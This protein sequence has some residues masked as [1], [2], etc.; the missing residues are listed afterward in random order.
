MHGAIAWFARNHVA[1][2][3]LMVVIVAAGIFTMFNRIPLEVFPSFERDVINVSASY[4][5]A[6]PNEVEEGVIR[7]IEESVADIPEIEHIISTASEGSAS[8][9]LEVIKGADKDKLL[10]EVKSR[11][12]AI[13][14]LPDDV[15]SPVASTSVRTRENINVIVYGEM[16]E[17]ELN[18]E[19]LKVRDELLKQPGITQVAISGL[20]P[21]EVAIEI[22]EVTLQRYGL[23]LDDV[24]QAISRSSRDIPAGTLKTDAG[25]IRIRTL[26]KVTSAQQFND[27]NIR[28][29]ADGTQITLGDIATIIDG[30]DEG[31]QYTTFDGKR[32]ASLE[33]YRVGDQSAIELSKAVIE[34]VANK[35]DRLP[36]NIT[37]TY[38]RDNSVSL[39]ARLS[40]LVTSAAQGC[41]L[42]FILLALF[43]RPIVALWVSVGIPISF[44][45][46]MIIM[47]ELGVTF[48]QIS[49]FAFIIV[50]GIVV[51]DAIVTGENIY[52]HLQSGSDPTTSAIQGT[53]EVSVPV[54]FG[55]LTT[56]TAFVPLLMVDGLRGQIFAVI[57][58]VIIPVLLFSLIESK[59]ILPA[60]MTSVRR[61]PANAKLNIISR[62]QRGI[63]GS[64]EWFIHRVF[65][66]FLNVA[67]NLRYFT[68]T[69]FVALLVLSIVA[70]N[71]GRFAFTFF[72]RIQ[73]EYVSADLTMPEGTPIEV[74]SKHVDNMLTQLLALQERYVDPGTNESVIRHILTTVGTKGGSRRQLSSGQSNIARIQFE[75]TP[76][77]ARTIKV[78]SLDMIR[79]W[80]RMIGDIPG[81]ESL[82]FRA[83]IG[84]GGQPL[85]IQLNGD[86]FDELSKAS[87]D[88]KKR[89]ANYSGLF[90]ITDSFEGGKDEI[91]MRIKP[92]AEML[93]LSLTDLGQQIRNSIFGAEAQTLARGSE[94][95]KV[96]V[97][98]PKQ[99]RYSVTALEKI[100]IRTSNGDLIPLLEVADVEIQQGFSK[101][102]RYD[103]Q[104][105]LTIAADAD[106]ENV[107]MPRIQ[108]EMLEWLPQILLS[109]PDVGYSFEGELK[110]QSEAFGS[111]YFGLAFALLGIYCLL[112]IPF[113]SYVQ[114]FIVMGVIPFSIIGS[115]IGHA[116]MGMTLSISSILGMLALTG[117]VVNDSLVLVDYINRKRLEG[118]DLLEAV[119]K[120]GG[121]RFRPILLTSLT[122]FAGLLP[123]MFE[124]STQ[125][126]FLIPMAVSLGYGILFATL[127]SLV[128][129][130]VSYLVL[131][132]IKR[133]L[134]W[135]YRLVFNIDESEKKPEPAS[136]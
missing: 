114:P 126:Q 102:S 43:L 51:D 118:M 26:G 5:G 79:D 33:V 21:Y 73:S 76:P 94:D 84:R 34:Y 91:R 3:L 42:I 2:N 47:P 35:N 30:F 64:L 9:S 14:D 128:L 95:A 129:V 98:L 17:M 111:L 88:I 49:L 119:R 58:A 117:V 41:L 28:S 121:A 69:F 37:L 65:S 113:R 106:K 46:A 24:S 1:A 75:T 132:D 8:V 50:L 107:D 7:K 78:S 55:V 99:E 40:T 57:P 36:E 90:D 16:T 23:S 53:Q 127:L 48:N 39:K 31:P 4:S 101:I 32:G 63:A 6:A 77:E 59:L 108:A 22:P 15:D 45:G 13:T 70:I 25:D 20:R 122:T 27:I 123:L 60:H 103:G 93:G 81:V 112:A 131:E 61:R 116:I 136:T 92:E 85:E 38:W 100:R 74:T 105:V 12:D 134:H 62:I 72:P 130:P 54:T 97:R 110:E 10:N 11:L 83:E 89:L 80:Q 82:S 96:I 86:N 87:T 133:I 124:K 44:M 120:A 56:M 68:L 109:Y 29:N 66:P 125:A 135:I 104:R 52:T 19:T 18:K 71:T 67:L 115:L